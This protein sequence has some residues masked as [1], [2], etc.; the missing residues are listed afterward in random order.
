MVVEVACGGGVSV[1]AERCG[2]VNALGRS[3][4]EMGGCGGEEEEQ[5]LL[6]CKTLV[7]EGA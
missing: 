7:G 6:R 4:T 3:W 2:C 1:R 5:A